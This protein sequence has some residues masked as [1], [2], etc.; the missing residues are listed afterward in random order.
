MRKIL[1]GTDFSPASQH[2][3]NVAVSWAR[4]KSAALHIMHIVPPKRWLMGP[5][6]KDLRTLSAIHQRAGAA[7]KSLVEALDPSRE[8][9]ISTGLI[10]GTASVQIARTARDCAADLLVIGAR[11][12]HERPGRPPTLGG[13]SLK[14]LSRVPIPLLLV[15]NE[16]AANPAS[17]MAAADLSAASRDVLAWSRES[18]AAGGRITVFHA[19]EVPFAGRLETYGIARDSIDLYSEAEQ[20]EHQRELDALI[21]SAHSESSVRTIVERCDPIDGLF[22]HLQIL[23][24]DLIVLGSHAGRKRRRSTDAAGSVSRH[25]ALFAPTNVL[26]VPAA[27]PKAMPVE[28]AGEP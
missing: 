4:R 6:R 3:I 23:D 19:Y 11:G 5:W 20:K 1:V 17:V 15:R 12:E 10:S 8:L 13:T 2:A 9:E 7:L 21:A 27:S 22:K 16:R 26:I 14:L 25:M 18:V 28:S 24:P